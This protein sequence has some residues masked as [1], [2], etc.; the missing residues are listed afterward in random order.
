MKV[1]DLQEAILGIRGLVNARELHLY[2]VK[3]KLDGRYLPYTGC[4]EDTNHN[5]VYVYSNLGR[6]DIDLY[7]LMIRLK[8]FNN[9]RNI[10]LTKNYNLYNIV[11]V[12]IDSLNYEFV[13][14]AR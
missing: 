14:L 12:Y 9:C 10:V 1:I 2:S 7:D 6:V 4:S 8:K 5:R 13:L 3:I 11:G